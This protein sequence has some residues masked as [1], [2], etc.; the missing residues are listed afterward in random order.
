[1]IA[2]SCSVKGGKIKG[3]AKSTEDLINILNSLEEKDQLEIPANNVLF[4]IDQDTKKLNNYSL[5]YHCN[6]L[7]SDRAKAKE[8]FLKISRKLYPSQSS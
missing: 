1:M 8:D 2:F 5:N 4:T 3:S 7:F 6:T